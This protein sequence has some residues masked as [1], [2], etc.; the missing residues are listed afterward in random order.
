MGYFI[1]IYSLATY[2][3]NGL[4]LSQTQGAALQS[5]LAAGQVVGR[6]AAGW[7]LDA[8]GRCNGTIIVFILAGVSC[9][10]I[11]LPSR[12]FGVLVV[13]ALAQG[14]LGGTIWSATPVVSKSVGMSINLG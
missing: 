5:I 6:P 3:T 14:V 2:S 1:A 11:W 4:G 13:F 7:L 8:I 10:A 12:T 9:F